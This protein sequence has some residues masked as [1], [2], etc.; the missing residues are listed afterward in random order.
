M[1]M[2]YYRSAIAGLKIEV[3]PPVSGDVAPQTV[4]FDVYQEKYQGDNIKVGYL[5]T[6][7]SVAQKVLKNDINV[8]EIDEDE[9][10]Q[11]T[12]SDANPKVRKLT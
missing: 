9:F 2:K 1:A 7:N 3:G 12:D 4:S 11:N 10:N 6:D 5:A 8:E